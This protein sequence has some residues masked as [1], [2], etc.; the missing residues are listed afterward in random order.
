MF[1]CFNLLDLLL[2]ISEKVVNGWSISDGFFDVDRKLVVNLTCANFAQVA[3][4]GNRY[5][6][7]SGA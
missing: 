7:Q 6:N 5:S 1:A 4:N 2:D 3:D